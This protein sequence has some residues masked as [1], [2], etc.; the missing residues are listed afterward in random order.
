M[1]AVLMAVVVMLG[2][3][4][5]RVHVVIALIIGAVVGG[6]FGGLGLSETLN[7]FTSG[8][9]ASANIALSY[10]LLGAFAFAVS[11]TGLPQLFVK[12]CTKLVGREGETKQSTYTKVLLLL[13][14]LIMACFSQNVIPVHIAFI[15]ILV[16]PLLKVLNLL[17]LDR[18][19]VACILTFG[20]V[21]AYM[22]LPFGYGL[23]FHDIIASNI[24]GNGVSVDMAFV[25]RAMVLP[26]LGMLIGL[27]V[28]VFVTYRKPRQYQ[29][30]KLGNDEASQSE[31]SYTGRSIGFAFAA[32][33]L[34]LFTQVYTDS[35]V[36]GALSGIL[37]LY[38]SGAFS[39]RE[40][41]EVL[42][43]G[44][45]MMTFI[46]FVMISAAGFAEVLRETGDIDALVQHGVQLVGHNQFLAALLMLLI[47]LLVTI[48]IGSSFSTIPI[49]ATIFV[50]FAMELGFSH[51]AI[52][53]LIGTAG[54]LGD[55]G[56]PA[57]DSTLGPTAGLNADKQ[58]DHI[59]DTCVPTFI[60]YNIPLIIFGLIA[61]MVL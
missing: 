60:H 45:K 50:P 18:R 8:L 53:A 19:V 35:M 37:L 34:A 40:S 31:K 27:L 41:D 13:I 2:L 11:K 1:N 43:N 21:T 59:W 61:A 33:M 24:G 7:T 25:P 39:F 23:I 20:L 49:L 47:G 3:S 16:P 55:A 6:L 4:L 10:A 32:I 30:A 9:G 15:P 14:L 48:G 29:E 42:T 44:M 28:A 52:I 56:S 36:F 46:G 22:W 26:A 57:S 38:F 12:M 54:A 5:A 51:M 17:E 58:H